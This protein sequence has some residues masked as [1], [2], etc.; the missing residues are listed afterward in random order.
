MTT[1]EQT[2]LFEDSK[3]LDDH[4]YER[5]HWDRGEA[6]AG[7]DEA[8]RGCLAGPVVAAAVIMPPSVRIDGVTDSKKLSAAKRNELVD[9]IL[10]TSLCWSIGICSPKEID[11]LNILWA[12]M[13]AIRKAIVGLSVSPD[14]VLI[15]GNTAIPNLSLPAKS[16][17][18]GDLKSHSIAAASILAKTHRD[19]IMLDLHAQHPHYGWNT[20]VGYP[21]AAHYEALQKHGPTPYHRTTFRLA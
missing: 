19:R 7:V 14:F 13:E 15:D 11:S 16:I 1:I 3:T 21:T 5:P 2:V 12:S 18:K 9:L 10:E 20:N 17:V 4:A 6:V 8:G